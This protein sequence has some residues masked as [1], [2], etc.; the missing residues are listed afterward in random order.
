MVMLIGNMETLD[1]EV[2]EKLYGRLDVDHQI[3]VDES[4]GEFANNA[5][6]C[7]YWYSDD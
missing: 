5:V 7:D 6:G 4:I 2:F 1:S 3:E